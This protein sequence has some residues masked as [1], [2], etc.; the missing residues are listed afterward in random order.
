MKDL[1]LIR[2][3][4]SAE[5]L[6]NRYQL[7]YSID[8]IKSVL[9]GRRTNNKI[10]HSA[11]TF[12]LE[13]MYTDSVQL[14]KIQFELSAGESASNKFQNMSIEGKIEYIRKHELKDIH[15]LKIELIKKGIFENWIKDLPKEIQ[16]FI[17]K[18]N[19]NKLKLIRYK[20]GEMKYLPSKK[21]ENPL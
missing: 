17:R 16:E 8:T 9:L 14:K 11:C 2:K 10:V 13:T 19:R 18:P 5:N 7:E 1:E 21:G 3:Y 4:V 12:A 20:L 15:E 6:K